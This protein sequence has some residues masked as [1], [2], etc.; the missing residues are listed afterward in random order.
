M[1]SRAGTDQKNQKNVYLPRPGTQ[2]IVL[3]YIYIR[4]S[5]VCNEGFLVPGSRG[6]MEGGDILQEAV[7]N[8]ICFSPRVPCYHG[9]ARCVLQP[10]DCT[11]DG[12]LQAPQAPLLLVSQT[13]HCRYPPYTYIPTKLDHGFNN[14]K[15]WNV[16]PEQ[17]LC[18]GDEIWLEIM[19][20][21]S[22]H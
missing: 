16:E 11:E 3:T 21:G 18:S 9:A 2:S 15:L 17:K 4:C 19:T 5:M 20:Q 22:C 12:K 1:I 8:R 13:P 14:I 7:S 6:G 10:A